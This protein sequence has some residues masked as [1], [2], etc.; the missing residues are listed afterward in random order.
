M[1]L[2][3]WA[4]GDTSGLPLVACIVAVS[5]L[6][7]TGDLSSSSSKLIRISLQ[8]SLLRG[9]CDCWRRRSTFKTRPE[10]SALR[11]DCNR[12]LYELQPGRWTD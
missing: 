8:S 12:Q 7:G 5:L 11:R 1:G 4:V 6:S 10:V 2:L 9:T 3:L